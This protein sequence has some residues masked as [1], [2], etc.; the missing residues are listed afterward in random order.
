MVAAHGMF[1]LYM[2]RAA[3]I[4]IGSLFFAFEKY[5]DGFYGY[6]TGIWLRST[7]RAVYFVTLVILQWGNLLSV[8]NKRLS[9]LQADPF[10]AKRRN[11]WLPLGALF[12]LVTAIFVTEVPGFHTLFGTAPVPIEYWFIPIPSPSA[13]WCLTRFASSPCAPGQKAPLPRFRGSL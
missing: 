8:R 9:I 3:R 12:A 2:W 4:P 7:T 10:R 6:T 5:S 11:P 13:S 1:F